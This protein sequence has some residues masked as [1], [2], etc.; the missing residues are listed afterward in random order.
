ME[1]QS[2]VATESV[3]CVYAGKNTTDEQTAAGI[4]QG[5]W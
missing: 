2:K 5:R 3:G 1:L 4:G